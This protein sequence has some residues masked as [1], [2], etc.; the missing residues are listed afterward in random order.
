MLGL[1]LSIESSMSFRNTGYYPQLIALYKHLGV[2]FRTTDF[3]YSFSTLS[4]NSENTPLRGENMKTVMIYNGSSGTKGVGI[5]SSLFPSDLRKSEDNLSKYW[6]I[7]RGYGLYFLQ[8]LLVLFLYLRLLLFSLPIRVTIPSTVHLPFGKQVNLSQSTQSA[9]NRLLSMTFFRPASGITLREWTLHTT[10]T[11]PAF[12]LLRLNVYWHRFIADVVIPLFSAVCTAGE[13]FIWE[14]PAEEILDYIW[15]TVGTHHYVVANGV[16]EVAS[17]MTGN[18]SK[19]QLHLGEPILE[20]AH[21]NEDGDENPK[22][23]IHCSNGKVYRGFS[24]VVFATQANH[25]STLLK[26]Y[27]DSCPESGPSSPALS[28]HKQAVQAQID[29]LSSFTYCPSIVVN[30]T[31]ESIL[32]PVESDRRDLNLVRIISTS[33]ITIEK[34]SSNDLC[35][36]PTYTMATHVLPPPPRVTPLSAIKSG[37]ATP[38]DTTNIYQTTNPIIPLQPE[39]VL[40]VAKMER[41]VVSVKG[42]TAL[43]ELWRETWETNKETE[44]QVW[45]WGCAGQD[46]GILGPLQGA[47]ALSGTR[48]KGEMTNTRRMPGIWICGSFAHCGIPLLEGCVVSGRNVVEQGIW[49]S[50]GVRCEESCW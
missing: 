29:C 3:S 30:H 2:K 16:R 33:S 32:P 46:G 7:A 35:L 8:T 9:L 28:L 18:M 5:P 13:D 27:L 39:S 24:H 25:G 36:P 44:E 49:V 14:M 38:P 45:R 10:P 42:K 21:S 20:L 48:D 40:S 31:D 11:Y 26:T 15:L 47:G 34:P 43:K 6:A 37:L 12:Q 41:A 4:P 17:K 50:E 19:D 22:V 23:D 1:F